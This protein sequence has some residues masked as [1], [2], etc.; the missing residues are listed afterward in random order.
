MHPWGKTCI[1]KSR[2]VNIK[3]S[4][5]CGYHF[6]FW[7]TFF[8]KSKISFKKIKYSISFGKLC[9]KFQGWMQILMKI[10]SL[11]LYWK[12]MEWCHVAYWN[13]RMLSIEMSQRLSLNRM[14]I[15]CATIMSC[16]EGSF[17][18]KLWLQ[19]YVWFLIGCWVM[20]TSMGFLTCGYHYRSTREVLCKISQDGSSHFNYVISWTKPTC[21]QWRL[22]SYQWFQITLKV[23]WNHWLLYNLHR[24]HVI[25]VALQL[26]MASAYSVMTNL[27]LYR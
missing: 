6:I 21:F 20:E 15:N 13:T 5:D 4:A 11:L 24:K 16:I 2:R 7:K 8:L 23:I 10:A 22:Y 27:G 26:L 19:M 3:S 1:T 14:L 12:L 9:H 25:C 17:V 18:S